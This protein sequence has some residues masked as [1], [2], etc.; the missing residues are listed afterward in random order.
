MLL[1]DFLVG[2]EI[3]FSRSGAK[4]TLSVSLVKNCDGYMA[5]GFCVIAVNVCFCLH[6]SDHHL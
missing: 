3:S 2:P 6:Q 5:T 4:M 1:S